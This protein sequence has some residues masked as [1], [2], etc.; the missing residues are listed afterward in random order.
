MPPPPGRRPPQLP[1]EEPAIPLEP[2][3]AKARSAYIRSMIDKIKQLKGAGKTVDEIKQQDGLQR[4]AEDYPQLF[5]LLTKDE[6]YNEGSLRTMLAM[7][8]K[9]GS[10]EISQHQASV[11]VGQRLHDVFIKPKLSEQ[12]H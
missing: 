3:V 4:F 8:E 11:I 10:G 5:K 6:D 7:M 9:M 12:E 1:K 2:A